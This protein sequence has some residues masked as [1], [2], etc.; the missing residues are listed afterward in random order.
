[1]ADKNVPVPETAQRDPEEWVTGGEPMTGP[2]TSY[3]NTLAH[4][5]GE[6]TKEGLS[7]AEASEEIDR[8]QE[9]TGRGQ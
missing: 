6:D 3:L 9:K 7:K 2:Q 8:L 1:M 5:A 4:E